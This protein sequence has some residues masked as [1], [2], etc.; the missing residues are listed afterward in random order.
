LRLPKS[1]FFSAQKKNEGAGVIE[2]IGVPKMK[3]SMSESGINSVRPEEGYWFE[4]AHVNRREEIIV[5]A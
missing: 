3:R 4:T 2:A 1:R 5:G